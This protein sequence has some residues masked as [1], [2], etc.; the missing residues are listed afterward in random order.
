MKYGNSNITMSMNL[1]K[2]KLGLL[3]I[4]Q[5]KFNV[6]CA[7]LVSLG[8]KIVGDVGFNFI[9]KTVVAMITEIR[10]KISW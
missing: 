1:C 3:G 9:R 7:S 8:M 10:K 6:F 2:Y 4:W 5:L